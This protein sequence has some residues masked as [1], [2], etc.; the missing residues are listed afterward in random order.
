MLSYSELPSSEPTVASDRIPDL[1]DAISLA[2]GPERACSHVTIARGGPQSCRVFLVAPYADAVTF[3]G[4]QVRSPRQ[5]AQELMQFTDQDARYPERRD[6][7]TRKGWAI[8]KI[9]LDGNPVAV[10]EAAWVR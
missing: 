10:A 3:N 2:I 9:E 7:T 4:N 6:F 5:I 1:T 8:R